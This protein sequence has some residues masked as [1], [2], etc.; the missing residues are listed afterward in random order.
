MIL[1]ESAMTHKW[2]RHPKKRIR[3]IINKSASY[4]MTDSCNYEAHSLK[5][6]VDSFHFMADLFIYLADSSFSTSPPWHISESVVQTNEYITCFHESASVLRRGFRLNG[7]WLRENAAG[8]IFWWTN[9]SLFTCGVWCMLSCCVLCCRVW[10]CLA[11][12]SL[13]GLLSYYI[14]S[15]VVRPCLVLSCV[16]YHT[17]TLHSTSIIMTYLSH[18]SVS[19][20]SAWTCSW[21]P[22]PSIQGAL[23]PL[24]TGHTFATI[25]LL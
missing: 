15:C 19:G 25:Y 22:S 3:H 5:H 18:A 4:F 16:L 17:N 7:A 13:S 11:L 24:S 23:Q 2:I 10:F 14:L 8:F 9:S 6:M 1:D 12:S 20:L 21:T